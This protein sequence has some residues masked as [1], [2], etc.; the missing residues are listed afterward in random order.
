[1]VDYPMWM[2]SPSTWMP[3]K[4][5]VMKDKHEWKDVTRECELEWVGVA[6]RSQR[7]NLIHIKHNDVVVATVER[8]GI[9]A[10]GDSRVAHT[11][12]RAISFRIE[13]RVEAKQPFKI[14][15]TPEFVA[16]LDCENMSA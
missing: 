8:D 2:P 7:N 15:Y 1:M 9:C 6:P 3:I 16:D 10:S 4:E 13:R 14:R 5:D 12:D 11:P